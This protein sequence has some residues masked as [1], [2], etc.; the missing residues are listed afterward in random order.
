MSRIAVIA[1]GILLGL[2]GTAPS[3]YLFERALKKGRS[4]SVGA[5]IA[6]ILLSFALLVGSLLVARSVARESV[7]P[8]GCAEVASLL[9]VW[10]VEAWRAWRDAGADASSGERE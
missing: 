7:L 2:V 8:L 1:I 4:V 3:A 10:A 9:L 5:G 6:S